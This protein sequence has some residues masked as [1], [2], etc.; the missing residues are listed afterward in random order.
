MRIIIEGTA[1]SGKTM[2]ALLIQ[3]A[4]QGVGFEVTVKGEDDS[5]QALANKAEALKIG[6]FSGAKLS[7]VRIEQVRVLRRWVSTQVCQG[8]PGETQEQVEERAFAEALA[9]A[10]NLDSKL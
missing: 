1:N 6:G 9:V 7:P 10:R 3:Q 4:L 8:R 5:P 2:A